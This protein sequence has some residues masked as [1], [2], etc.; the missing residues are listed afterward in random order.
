MR[1][2][3]FGFVAALFAATNV[4]RG[5]AI[6]CIELKGNRLLYAWNQILSLNFAVDFKIFCKIVHFC[7]MKVH[8]RNGLAHS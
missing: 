4:N 8:F 5:I 7:S 6:E 2:E 3:T 1:L